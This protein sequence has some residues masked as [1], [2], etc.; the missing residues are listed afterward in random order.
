MFAAAVA[1]VHPCSDDGMEDNDRPA[2]VS[3]ELAVPWQEV[4]Q[5]NIGH[6]NNE[7]IP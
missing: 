1:R 3:R 4:A 5:F 6:I 2:A 7:G